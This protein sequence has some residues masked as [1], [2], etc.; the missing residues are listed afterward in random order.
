[1]N[2]LS[3]G[4]LTALVLAAIA[5]GGYFW[6]LHTP[7]PNP[8]EP[9]AAPATPAAAG[10]H[11]RAG[12]AG[13]QESDRRR[14]GAAARARPV[15]RDGEVGADRA[16]RLEGGAVVPATRGLSAQGRRDGR[17]PVAPACG[18]AALA[19]QPDARALRRRRDGRPPVIAPDNGAALRAVR[20][21][22]RIGRH[23]RAVAL[24]ARLYP[25][26]QQAYEELGYP[27]R[28][29]NDR[30]V[31]VI[32]DLLATPEPTG[33]VRADADR[34]QGPGRAGAALAA[35]RVRRPDARIA[36]GRAEDPA[37]HRPGQRAPA[38][39]QADRVPPPDRQRGAG[40][41][42]APSQNTQR[43]ACGI[44][45]QCSPSASGALP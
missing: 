29:F 25:L 45:S 18:A 4:L 9:V 28:Y 39:G 32:D 23:A 13:D 16:G 22:R 35:L 2:R 11:G 8:A 1:M 12:G 15:R 31:E 26:F 37:A 34:D 33:P 20:A 5:V 24:Y 30:L 21:V 19:G 38:E 40:S 3:Y 36:V 42:I 27:G 41:L 14:V 43:S 6:W 44:C 7:Q 10:G 17:Q